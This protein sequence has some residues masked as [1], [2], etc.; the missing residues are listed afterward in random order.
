VF[1]YAHI[2]NIHNLHDC[3]TVN[4]SCIILCTLQ[5]CSHR[6]SDCKHQHSQMSRHLCNSL[7]FLYA[8]VSQTLLLADPY[9]F[10][11]YP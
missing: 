4:L 9:N 7:T 11:I 8:S 5:T 1:K 10:E 6:L 3:E 2:K